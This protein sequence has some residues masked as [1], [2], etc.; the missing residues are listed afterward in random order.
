[1][2]LGTAKQFKQGI[3]MKT[4]N[5]CVYFEFMSYA[6]NFFSEIK[7]VFVFRY[8]PAHEIVCNLGLL[9]SMTLPS[10]HSLTGCDMVSAFYGKGK[11]T[12]WG[13]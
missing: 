1:M 11:K 8:I 9:R 6:L 13:V 7:I 5:T 10:F 3:V 12:A 4:G 2:A